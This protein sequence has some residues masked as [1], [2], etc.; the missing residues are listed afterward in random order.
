LI[1]E[2]SGI[3]E[4]GSSDNVSAAICLD[5][6]CDDVV[7]FDA[8]GV[9]IDMIDEQTYFIKFNFLGE[10]GESLSG[11]YQGTFET[12]IIGSFLIDPSQ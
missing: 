1:I 5:A 3:Y 10:N 2:F 6:D 11:Q 8:G 7:E 9:T 4:I 12:V